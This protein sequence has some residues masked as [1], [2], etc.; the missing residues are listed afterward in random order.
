MLYR[1]RRKV[2]FRIYNK[3]NATINCDKNSILL[4]VHTFNKKTYWS[5]DEVL[6][7]VF[8]LDGFLIEFYEDF[9]FDYYLEKLND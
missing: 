2:I 4:L 1:L 9:E 8:Y 6:F 3:E 5:D 7:Y